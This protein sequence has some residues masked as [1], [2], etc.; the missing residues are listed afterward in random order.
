M[1]VISFPHLSSTV[2]G[3]MLLSEARVPLSFQNSC[4]LIL[5]YMLTFL[6][7]SLVLNF[8]IF[9]SILRSDLTILDLF[10]LLLLVVLFFNF[11]LLLINCLILL[12]YICFDL[13]I[14]RFEKQSFNIELSLS[15]HFSQ[16]VST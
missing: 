5:K 15:D 8:A 14:S 12:S 7:R 6:L 9:L 1:S 3:T 10:Y 2:W 4:L 13:L 11:F 16:L